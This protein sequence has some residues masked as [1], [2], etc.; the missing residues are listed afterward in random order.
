MRILVVGAGGVGGYFGGRLAEAGRDVTFLVRPQRAEKLKKD[1]LQIISSHGNTTLWPKCVTAADIHNSY[2]LVLLSVKGYSLASAL[3]DFAPA[4]GS[5]TIILPTLNGMRHLEQLSGRFGEN[6][7]MGG[8]CLI[9]AE[10]DVRERIVQMGDIADL[11]YGELN[12]SKSARVQSLDTLLQ[13]AGFRA[14]LSEH[15]V[16]D[17]WQK[18]V[19][20]ASLGAATCLTGGNIGQIVAVERGASLCSA[21]LDECAAIADSAGFPQNQDVLE[22]H[23]TALTGKG[24][25]LTSSMYRDLKKGASVEVDTILGDLLRHA[26]KSSLITPLLNATFVQLSIYQSQRHVA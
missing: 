23:R 2:D 9:A 26:D 5:D 25:S 10:L 3:Q 11:S 4:V 18:W 19:Q 14:H 8:V 12:G 17:M 7:V 16:A 21:I 6:S 22:R 1:G 20:L 24:S 13:G 15:I